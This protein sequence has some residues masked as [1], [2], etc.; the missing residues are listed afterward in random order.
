MTETRVRT[1][2]ARPAPADPRLHYLEPL[3]TTPFHP[4][5]APLNRLWDWQPWAGCVTA[6]GFGDEAMEH[7]AIRNAAT[8]YDLCPMIKLRLRGPGAAALL[9]RVTLRSAARMPVGAVQYTAWCDGAGKVL[10][11]G[12]LFRLGPEDFRLCSQERHLPWLLDSAHGFDA[13]IEDE[14]EGIAALALQGPCAAAVLA[15]A[16]WDVSDL[17]PFRL[18]AFDGLTVSRTGF[19]GDLGY[20]LWTDPAGAL[21]LW[22]RLM[23]AGAPFGLRPIGSTALNVARIE[24]GLLIANQDFVPAGQALREDRA[25]S[26]FELGLDWMI[27]WDKGQ[28]NGR[29]AL[30]REREKGSEWAT[31][32]LDVTGNVPAEGAILYL[33][34]RREVG[35][36]T[37]ACWSP[38]LKRSLAIA[39]V[40][41]PHHESRDLW[42]EI[43]ALRELRYVKLMERARPVPRPFLDLPR[44]KAT[45]PEPIR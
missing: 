33:G 44:R 19:T 13:A 32:G 28:F 12:T 43:Y 34:K 5:T 23:E 24:A 21:P 45:P 29:R 31:V 40:R 39:Q 25:R 18:A 6:A 38:T 1:K 15:R 11:D 26:P 4:R 37:S 8:L 27:D 9:D 41:R 42:A 30:L 16:G 17:R 7:A 2:G 3:R 22:D 36:V 20:E 14:T 10:D 35:Q